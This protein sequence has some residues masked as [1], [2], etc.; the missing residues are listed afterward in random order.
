MKLVTGENEM[1]LKTCSCEITNT[2]GGYMLQC[3]KGFTSVTSKLKV[4]GGKW[5]Y[6]AVIISSG[7]KQIGWVTPDFVPDEN[8][9]GVGDDNNSWA[10]DGFRLMAWHVDKKIFLQEKVARE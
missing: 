2:D 3:R 1:V 10:Y 7:L 6:E 8:G 9:N 4:T 5:Y